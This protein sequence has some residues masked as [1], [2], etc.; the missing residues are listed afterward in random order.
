MAVARAVQPYYWSGIAHSVFAK[1]AKRFFDV[2]LQM[3]NG[4]IVE[5]TELYWKLI[6]IIITN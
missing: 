5:Q 2:R 1:I 6:C 3:N 4:K